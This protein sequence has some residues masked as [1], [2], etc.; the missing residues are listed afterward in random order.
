M[1]RST[2]PRSSRPFSSPPRRAS[3]RRVR[4][5]IE[6][7]GETFRVGSGNQSTLSFADVVAAALVDDGAITVKGTFTC[8]PDMQGGKHRGGAVGSTMGFSYARAG[9]R[10]QRRRGHRRGHGRQGVGRARLRPRH[11]SAG[12]RRPDRGIGVDGD[13]PGDVRGDPLPR[14]PA[15]ARQ[16]SRI[17]HADHRRNR[18]RSKSRS[19]KAHDPYGPF[20]AKEAS[21][22]ALA[23]FPP[24][25]VNAIAN[26]IGID[27]DRIAG[28]ARPGHGRAHPA[29]AAGEA[30]QHQEGRIMTAPMAEFRLAQP[31]TVK[32]AVAA[33]RRTS[34]QPLRRRRHRPARQHA[35]RHQ[36]PGSAGRSFR[37][38]RTDRDRERRRRRD[39]R[40]RRDH[41]RAGAQHGDRR[42]ISR[43]GASRRSDRR[44]RPSHHGD[45]R[46]QS[47]PR[48]PLH[49]STIKANGGAAPTP[50]AS[51]TAAIS[52]MSPRRANVATPPSA[53]TWR[54]PCSCSAPKS[55]SPAHK[56]S[57]AFR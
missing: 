44:T 18:R 17:S 2:R 43:A 5:D 33:A 14:R 54:R 52:A 45:R 11:Q 7:V 3:S 26:A 28:D 55:R 57:A 39:D 37:H 50:I 36:Q 13:G 24:A 35:A 49:L 22:G 56:A 34:G 38:R 12:G 9:G 31:G 32:E 21:E 41:R 42:P 4:E 47:V 19:S 53:A 27:L 1:R 23:G 20:G 48:H 25:L 40:R 8:P 30:R 10:G 6:C 29:P 16:L 15:A 51:R 46:R